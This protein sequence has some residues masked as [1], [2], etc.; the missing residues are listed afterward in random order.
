MTLTE[1]QLKGMTSSRS[2]EWATPQ[3]LAIGI[4]WMIDRTPRGRFIEFSRP[5]WIALGV[6]TVHTFGSLPSP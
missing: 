3:W 2:D 5:R 4:F 1:E 6:R